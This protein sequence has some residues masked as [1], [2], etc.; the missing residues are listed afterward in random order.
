VHVL[1]KSFEYKSAR[2]PVLTK[3]DMKVLGVDK[4]LSR[5]DELNDEIIDDS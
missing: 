3:L 1:T 5:K 4:I 2:T